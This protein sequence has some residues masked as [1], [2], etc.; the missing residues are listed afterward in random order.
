MMRASVSSRSSTGLGP[1]RIRSTVKSSTFLTSLTLCTDDCML[2]GGVITRV[3]ENTTSSAVKGAPSWNLTPRRSSK[4]T[5]VGE[6]CV[7]LVASAG[8]I[9]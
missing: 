4:R 9:W 3:M 6:I 7:H 1:L 5:C 8:W 2:D